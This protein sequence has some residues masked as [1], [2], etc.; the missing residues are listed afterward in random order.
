M[1]PPQKNIILVFIFFKKK[2]RIVFFQNIIRKSS[3]LGPP[4]L[5][6]GYGSSHCVFSVEIRL[7]SS[8]CKTTFCEFHPHSSYFHNVVSTGLLVPKRIVG[9]TTPTDFHSLVRP[10]TNLA[11]QRVFALLA[12]HCELYRDVDGAEDVVLLPSGMIF[13]MLYEKGIWWMWIIKIVDLWDMD[14]Q[15][16][17]FG[18]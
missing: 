16:H 10:S 2:N 17:W 6:F 7:F 14:H 9:F 13:Q 5:T 12:I 18:G 8:W 3:S 15:F 4:G 11:K 1:R